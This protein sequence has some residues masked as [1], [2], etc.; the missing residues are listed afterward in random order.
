MYRINFSIYQLFV[1]NMDI[2]RDSDMSCY[3]APDGVVIEESIGRLD[4]TNYTH[5]RIYVPRGY[6]ASWYCFKGRCRILHYV[7]QYLKITNQSYEM[8]SYFNGRLQ[9]TNSK[10]KVYAC[11]L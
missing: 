2:V 11:Y 7:L 6:S 1:E 8:F 10:G 3:T 9:L 5:E 4:W